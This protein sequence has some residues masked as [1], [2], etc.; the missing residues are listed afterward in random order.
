MLAKSK[1][2][3]ETATM[4]NDSFIVTYLHDAWHKIL[5]KPV[6]GKARELKLPGIGS[7]G[8][9]YG[10]Q[11]DRETF[12]SWTSFNTPARIYHLDPETGKSTLFKRPAVK[13]NPDDY[14][15]RQ[16]F[17]NSKDGTR[18]PMFITH[19]KGLKLDGNNPTLLYGY[20][21]FNRC[22]AGGPG[23]P[24]AHPHPHRDPGRSRCGHT[25]EQ[26][27]RRSGGQARLPALLPEITGI[28]HEH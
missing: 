26:A 10:K 4:V 19:K 9:F 13:F 27:H 12:Y 23:R 16:V 15:T 25:D 1:D 17:Y 2:T 8:G 22:T 7:A 11:H 5:I 24:G 6:E 21:G 20:G 3:I 18:V 14:V 28:F